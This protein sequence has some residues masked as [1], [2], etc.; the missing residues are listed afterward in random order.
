MMEEIKRFI[1]PDGREYVAFRALNGNIVIALD[2]HAY[3][4][5][6]SMPSTIDVSF[7]VKVYNYTVAT[8]WFTVE[9]SGGGAPWSW[10]SAVQLGACGSGANIIRHV[11]SLGTRDKPASATVDATILTFRAYSDDE[12]TIEVGSGYP[13]V[14]SYHWIDSSAMS[15]LDEDNF[16]DG[17]YKIGL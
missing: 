1:A 2:P 5:I 11:P 4:D 15:L 17:T 16:D 10:A 8:L 12:Y 7:A 9:G 3:Q 6:V 13:I 14:V